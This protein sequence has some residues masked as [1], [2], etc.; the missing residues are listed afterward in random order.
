MSIQIYFKDINP[1]PTPPPPPPQV[2]LRSGSAHA[3]F[4]ISE[5]GSE[6]KKKRNLIEKTFTCVLILQS[7]MT[8]I[9]YTISFQHACSHASVL[10]SSDALVLESNP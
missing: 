4:M 6:R 8:Q 10:V 2:Y 1:P 7:E 9:L 5:A 3:L